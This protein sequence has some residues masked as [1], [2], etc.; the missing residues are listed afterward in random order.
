MLLITL[1][2]IPALITSKWV[3]KIPARPD[4]SPFNNN[5]GPPSKPVFTSFISREESIIPLR[6]KAIKARIYLIRYIA[7][8][9]TFHAICL[10]FNKVNSICY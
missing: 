3:T 2:L 4:S 10:Q 6:A 1:E 7:M 8:Q 5:W 9:M